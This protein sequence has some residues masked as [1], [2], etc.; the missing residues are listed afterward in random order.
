MYMKYVTFTESVCQILHLFAMVANSYK[1]FRTWLHSG[2]T[3]LP[4]SSTL[5]HRYVL[6]AAV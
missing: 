6:A 3:E 1:L 4:P 2:R 5:K